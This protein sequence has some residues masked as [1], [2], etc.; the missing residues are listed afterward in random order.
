MPPEEELDELGEPLPEFFTGG[1]YGLTLNGEWVVFF[2]NRSKGEVSYLSWTASGIIGQGELRSSRT[3]D[4][5]PIKLIPEEQ[6]K[7]LISL[8]DPK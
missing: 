4:W 2:I 7:V 6:A 3:Q 8:W 1:T 5:L